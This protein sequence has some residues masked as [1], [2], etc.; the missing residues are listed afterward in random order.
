ML[1][2][3]VKLWV[4]ALR[5]GEYKQTSTR[6]ERLGTVNSYCCLGVA[7]KV[8]EKEGIKLEFN[9]IGELAGAGLENQTAVMKWLK[10]TNPDGYYSN[11]KQ[12][13]MNDNDSQ[14]KTFPEIA[15]IIEANASELF[16]QEE[17]QC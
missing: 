9:S 10:I 16:E 12:S 4:E 6:L 2:E 15:D 3:N 7:C 11:R 1:N 17:I 5:S 14:G 8:A 13:L